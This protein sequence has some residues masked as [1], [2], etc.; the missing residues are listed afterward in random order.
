MSLSDFLAEMF[1]REGQK[2][3]VQPIV[4]QYGS[5]KSYTF[6]REVLRDNFKLPDVV[7]QTTAV[8]V[9]RALRQ[10]FLP[11]M[12]DEDF[13]NLR[14]M[15]IYMDDVLLSGLKDP[16]QWVLPQGFSDIPFVKS[17]LDK[18]Y[19]LTQ[20]IEYIFCAARMYI[21]LYRDDE[22]ASELIPHL[23]ELEESYEPLRTR[24][25]G[26]GSSIRGGIVPASTLE[27]AVPEPPRALGFV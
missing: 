9:L 16:H 22:G 5:T 18:N 10:F 21:W 14:Q 17:R 8:N 24:L 12:A 7:D 15:L 4:V 25:P 26:A 2:T 27:E 13:D 19:P 23:L 6:R 11:E 1:R 20:I 3:D